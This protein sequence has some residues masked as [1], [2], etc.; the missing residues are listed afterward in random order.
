[1]PNIIL[2]NTRSEPLLKDGLV[3]QFMPGKVP[4]ILSCHGVN[5]N[6]EFKE[7]VNSNFQAMEGFRKLSVKLL[8]QFVYNYYS[9]LTPKPFSHKQLKEYLKL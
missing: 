8:P 7:T 1:M 3:F 2:K 5:D 4:R 6:T 9:D